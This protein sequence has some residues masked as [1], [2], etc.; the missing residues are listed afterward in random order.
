VVRAPGSSGVTIQLGW[1][2]VTV[3]SAASYSKLTLMV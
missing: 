2:S 1:D 3:P